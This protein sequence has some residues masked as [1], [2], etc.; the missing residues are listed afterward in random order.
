MR[1]PRLSFGLA[2][3]VLLAGCVGSGSLPPVTH[4]VMA[5][6]SPAQPA[7]P[8]PVAGDLAVGG[9]NDDSFYDG[10]SLVFSREPG[11]RSLYQFAAWTDRPSRRLAVLAE[12][13]LDARG[14]FAAVSNVTAGVKADLLLNVNLDALYHDLTVNPAVAR[15]E[16]IAELLDWRTRTLLGRRSFA[17]TVPVQSEDAPGA[18]AAMNRGVTDILD[19]LVPWVEDTATARR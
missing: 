16:V 14:R 1:H 7:T 18:V 11:R 6:L 15:V 4:Y 13:R 17:I 19:A 8:S 9:G 12:R 5:D 10:D 2:A 3:A